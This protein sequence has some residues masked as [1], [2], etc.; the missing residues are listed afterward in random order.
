MCCSCWK[1]TVVTSCVQLTCNLLAIAT[2]LVGFGFCSSFLA[3]FLRLLKLL[4]Q[5]GCVVLFTGWFHRCITLEHSDASLMHRWNQPVNK[6][7]HHIWRACLMTM[8]NS[9]IWSCLSWLQPELRF[10]LCLTRHINRSEVFPILESVLWCSA[11]KC[12]RYCRIW[13]CF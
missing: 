13:F 12:R 8:L 5:H 6:T 11:M 9:R 3:C 10:E 4:I 7:M 1:F 2:F